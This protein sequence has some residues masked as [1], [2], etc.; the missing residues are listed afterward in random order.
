M[1]VLLYSVI[2][3]KMHDNVIHN[4][5]VFSNQWLASSSEKFGRYVIV[6]LP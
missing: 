6:R 4:Y 5:I 3:T 1:N 2:V